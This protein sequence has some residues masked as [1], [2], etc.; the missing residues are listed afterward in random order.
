MA[1][2]AVGLAELLVGGVDLLVHAVGAEDLVLG[3][4]RGLF[5]QLD[6][7]LVGLA[8]VQ[9]RRQVV[10]NDRFDRGGVDVVVQT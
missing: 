6:D 1:A 3:R 4:G 5:L 9:V 7:H 2:L 10:F 8:D